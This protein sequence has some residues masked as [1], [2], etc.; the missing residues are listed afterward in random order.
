MNEMKKTGT[1]EL[2]QEADRR[3]A[4]AQKWEAEAAAREAEAAECIERAKQAK[5][6]QVI[7]IR[8]SYFH[9]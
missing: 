3:C 1:R 7:S 4:E 6:Q 8:Y 5:V 2:K 9:L